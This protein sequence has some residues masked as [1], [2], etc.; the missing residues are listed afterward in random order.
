VP[1][2]GTP[3]ATNARSWLLRLFREIVLDVWRTEQA[4]ARDVEKIR[5]ER[6]SHLQGKLDRLEEAFIYEQSIDHAT[7]DRQRDRLHEELTFANL[8]LH[9]ARIGSLDVDGILGSQVS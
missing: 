5:T 7:Y 8:E 4:R 6:V 2:P 1:I 3:G 9:D